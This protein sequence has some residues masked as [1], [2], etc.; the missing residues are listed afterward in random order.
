MSGVQFRYLTPGLSDFTIMNS[1]KAYHMGLINSLSHDYPMQSPWVS[2]KYITYHIFSEIL[3][4]I[5]VRVFGVPVDTMMLSFG[6]IWTAYTF[7]LSTYS[8]FREMSRRPERAGVYSLL[9]ADRQGRDRI[10]RRYRSPEPFL[11]EYGGRAS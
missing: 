9:S 11:R 3:L 7:S 5:P 1:D 8:F 10:G 6:P 4:S 2:G